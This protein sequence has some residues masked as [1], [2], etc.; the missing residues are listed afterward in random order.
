MSRGRTRTHGVVPVLL[1]IH[2]LLPR[3]SSRGTPSAQP[4]VRAG[5]HPHPPELP[6]ISD[7]ATPA[8]LRPGLPVRAPRQSRR[9]LPLTEAASPTLQQFVFFSI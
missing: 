4:P 7:P 3:L 5:H 9:R 6:G 2:A 8:G 1:L